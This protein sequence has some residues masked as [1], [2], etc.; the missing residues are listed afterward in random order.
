MHE[1]AVPPALTAALIELTALRL[2]EVS[3]WWPH[4]SKQVDELSICRGMWTTDNNH[5]AQ[6]QF[7]TGRHRL[8]GFYPTIGSWV[9]YGLG[10]LSDNLPQFVVMTTPSTDL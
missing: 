10:K 2:T 4:L 7:H 6:L 1:I 9:H 8:D 5:G 3:D